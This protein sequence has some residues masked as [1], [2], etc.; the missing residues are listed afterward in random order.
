MDKKVRNALPNEDEGE[1]LIE[2]SE[3]ADDDEAPPLTDLAFC[4]LLLSSEAVLVLDAV[5]GVDIA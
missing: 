1:G 4:K 5:E 2:K 3:A